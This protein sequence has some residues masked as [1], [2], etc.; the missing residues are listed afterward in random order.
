MVKIGCAS[1]CTTRRPGVKHEL[2]KTRKVQT[3]QLV[4]E[5]KRKT[6]SLFA[7][8]IESIFQYTYLSQNKT[9]QD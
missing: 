7:F 6:F 5:T 2:S 8:G 3:S 9:W 4:I 1:T